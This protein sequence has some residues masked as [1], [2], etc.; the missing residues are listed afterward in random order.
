MDKKLL[1]KNSINNKLLKKNDKKGNPK[2][3]P[4][5]KIF[6]NKD[7]IKAQLNNLMKLDSKAYGRYL[8]S[9]DPIQGKIPVDE[10]DDI[11]DSSITCGQEESKK[12]LT[13]YGNVSPYE[14]AKNLDINLIIKDRSG[15]L[16]YIYFG[17]FESPK[18]I[19]LYEGNIVAADKLINELKI[20]YFKGDFK[21]IVLAHEL[22]HYVE[23]HNK[24][25]YT[26][27]RRIDLWS[28]GTLY[29]HTSPLICPGEIAGMSFAK[30]L[31]ELDFDPNVLNYIFLVAYDFDKADKLYRRIMHYA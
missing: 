2:Q 16:D 15:L 24:D 30:T 6:S 11:I 9:T 26:N 17:L 19:T 27:T 22:F 18:D 1:R 29:T 4:R 31:L 14:M 13:K 20:K 7:T 8:V 12:L 5:L 23:Y 3:D 10:I 21:D 28:I 25:L